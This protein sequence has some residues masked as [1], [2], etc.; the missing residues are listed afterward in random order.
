VTSDIEHALSEIK[1]LFAFPVDRM[2]KMIAA[3]HEEM[4]LGLAGAPG[5]LKMLPTYTDNPTGR[6]KGSFLALDL[7]GTN[8]RVLLADL[9]GDGRPPAV[10]VEKFRLSPEDISS[11][12]E[13][14]FGALARAIGAFLA[15]RGLAGP[16]GMGFTFSFPIRQRSL[17]R[18]ELITWTKGWSASGVVDNDVVELLN[19]ALAKEGVAGVRVVSLDNDTTGTQVARAYLDPDC[20]VGCILGTGTNMCYRERVGNILKPLGAYAGT[21]MIINMESGNLDRGLPRNRFDNFL[22]ADSE[23]PGEQ[24]EEK[25]V[26]GKYM[27]E[28]VRLAAVDLAGRGLLFGGRIPE[29]IAVR[30]SLGS[31]VVSEIMADRSA[32]G[33]GVSEVLVRLGAVGPGAAE[34]RALREICWT[35]SGRAARI[36]ATVM[37]AAVTKNDPNLD[38]AH[39]AAVDGSVFEKNPG[40]REAMETALGELLGERGDRL[41]L[42]LTHDG[43]GLGAAIIAASAVAPR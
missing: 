40:F 41:R 12:G 4:D 11:N 7:G 26:S 15:G 34:I 2:R 35:V 21:S 25:M 24:W 8:F 22:D 37:A 42:A 19:R 30:E 9:P 28:L 36:A 1:D 5:S 17:C 6:E 29:A 20:D 23:N 33:D 43:S 16:F 10:S 14:L 27:G 31:E 18:G 3:F 39:T 13:A 38:R 32:D